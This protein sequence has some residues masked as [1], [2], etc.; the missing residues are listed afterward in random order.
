MSDDK[1]PDQHQYESR[2]ARRYSARDS[3]LC[4]LV[5]T[6]V[7]ALFAGP[8]V[9]RAGEEAQPGLERTLLL[10]IGHPAGWLGDKLPFAD[11]ASRATAWLGSDDDL[12][13]TE[14]GFASVSNAGTGADGVPPVTPDSFDPTQ[15]GQPAPAPR[16]LRTLLVTGDSLSMPLDS[17][18]AR[19]LAD[20]GGVRV[21]RDPHV[22]TG[23]SKTDLLDWG[24]LATAQT[25]KDEPDAVVV[26]IGANEGFPMPLGGREVHCCGPE[27]AAEYAFRVRSMMD[28]Y[29]RGDGARVYWLTLPAPRDGERA[30]ITKAVNASIEVAAQPYRRQV[31]VLDMGGVFTPGGRY[32]DAMQVG[33]REE[34]V[35][36]SD[37]V[38]LNDAGSEVAADAVL[39]AV[40][41]DF[42]LR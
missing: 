28:T 40:G 41:R 42:R 8:A 38:H 32:R 26:F 21:L 3:V 31:R 37:G 27:W 34:I 23:I 2:F 18:L 15:L 19:R 10:A 36:E 30:R 39:A 6:V 25:R 33:G 4:I 35:R 20:R 17:I 7:L 12:D 14:G 13:S 22:G 1:V 5:M 11:A 9:R 29:R 24:R 16:A